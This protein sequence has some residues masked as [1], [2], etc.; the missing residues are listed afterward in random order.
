MGCSV[1]VSPWSPGL[2]GLSSA[3]LDPW[4]FFALGCPHAAHCT[5]SPLAIIHSLWCT[6]ISGGDTKVVSLPS[7]MGT[8]MRVFIA[9]RP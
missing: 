5:C 7:E 1:I 6:R 2:K 8:E 9:H 3:P 4:S